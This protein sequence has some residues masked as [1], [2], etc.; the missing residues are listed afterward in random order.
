MTKKA[1]PFYNS[2]DWR[3]LRD[4]VKA[5]WKHLNLPCGY[6]GKALDW[7]DKPIADHIQSRKEYPE[8]ALEEH[9]I[10]MVHHHCNTQKAKWHDNSDKPTIGED[11]YPIE[12]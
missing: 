5:R 8:L 7:K 6:C 3:D 10:Q 4:K 9:N 1:D 11:G 12:G 2:K